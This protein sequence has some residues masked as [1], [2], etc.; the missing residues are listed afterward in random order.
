MEI[1]ISSQIE[2]TSYSFDIVPN[3]SSGSFGFG[4]SDISNNPLLS[5]SGI[6]GK[7]YDND[8]KNFFS[9]YPGQSLSFSGNIFSG[10]HNYFVNNIPLNLNCTRT[11]GK[12]DNFY[13]NSGNSVS[14]NSV[15]IN[16]ELPEFSISNVFINGSGIT[17]EFE[18]ENLNSERVFKFYSGQIISGNDFN[19]LTFDSGNI[20]SGKIFNLVSSF[21]IFD[22]TEYP[23]LARFFTNFGVIEKQLTLSAA[24]QIKLILGLSA[25]SPV[26]IPNKEGFNLNGTGDFDFLLN[27]QPE[28]GLRT[29]N[30]FESNILVSLESISGEGSTPEF[31]NFKSIE[32]EKNI[33]L[34]NIIQGSGNVTGKIDFTITGYSQIEDRVISTGFSIESG[35]FVYVT[36]VFND[37]I[38]INV[39]G[40][41]FGFI[42]KPIA[43]SGI[44]ESGVYQFS[45]IIAGS[46]KPTVNINISV[47]GTV[48]NS[49]TQN[50]FNI[51]T[52]FEV[53]Q[54]LISPFREFSLNYEIPRTS[55]I[56][57][58]SGVARDR[59]YFFEREFSGVTNSGIPFFNIG[60]RRRGFNNLPNPIISKSLDLTG[61]GFDAEGNLTIDSFNVFD[62]TGIYTGEYSHPSKLIYTSGII[63][64]SGAYSKPSDNHA[65]GISFYSGATSPM[66]W[67]IED[68]G[69]VKRLY[70]PQIEIQPIQAPFKY[71]D[72][73]ECI[74]FY[75][76]KT[77]TNYLTLDTSEIE[78]SF[79]IDNRANGV[80]L[81]SNYTPRPLSYEYNKFSGII[82]AGDSYN[83]A[84]V[85][86]YLVP[87]VAKN[88]DFT[89]Y[90][91][92]G[93]W[94]RAINNLPYYFRM[95][96]MQDLGNIDQS[97]SLSPTES[98]SEYDAKVEFSNYNEILENQYRISVF[99][100]DITGDSFYTGFF[101]V[102]Q[103][104]PLSFEKSRTIG[105]PSTGWNGYRN[106]VIS[107]GGNVEQW[108]YIG[109][110][111][112][113][114]AAGN[115]PIQW[116]SEKSSWQLPIMQPPAAFL[117]Q[118][119]QV[120]D[121][122]TEPTG[123]F[124]S[125][126]NPF[127]KYFLSHNI[128]HP[129]TIFEEIGPD[130]Q[131]SGLTRSPIP[132]SGTVE[133]PYVVGV[134]DDASRVYRFNNNEQI[135]ITGGKYTGVI[136]S[137][138]SG[139]VVIEESGIT[140]IKT[141]AEV[142]S[143]KALVGGQHFLLLTGNEN[144]SFISA[145]GLISGTGG[146]SVP[147]TNSNT[148]PLTNIFNFSA[149]A[150]LSGKRH[151]FNRNAD[152]F[153][154]ENFSN[155]GDAALSLS[156]QLK[157][158]DFLIVGY[159]E[160]GSPTNKRAIVLQY[161]GLYT[162][163]IFLDYNYTINTFSTI[164]TSETKTKLFTKKNHLINQYLSNQ[165]TL[166]Q[167][168]DSGIIEPN[169]QPRIDI[170][171][172]F[173]EEYEVTGI[174]ST[175]IEIEQNIEYSSVLESGLKSGFFDATGRLANITNLTIELTT[176]DSGLF[177][178]PSATGN[179]LETGIL[180]FPPNQFFTSGLE[181]SKP[182]VSNGEWL[183]KTNNFSTSMPINLLDFEETLEFFP[184]YKMFTGDLDI[185]TGQSLASLVSFESSSYFN[186]NEKKF[187][188]SGNLGEFLGEGEFYI[189]IRNKKEDILNMLKLTVS[190]EGSLLERNI[191][192]N[193]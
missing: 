122:T 29:A 66:P 167:V 188:N 139:V 82:S 151:Y 128:S 100:R 19:F 166:N 138:G 189:V 13:F 160:S 96:N 127:G 142:F 169:F 115:F 102:T 11:T 52:G 164:T 165:V 17:G 58:L 121:S 78:P 161:T 158:S 15:S 178:S 25:I 163:D 76:T 103:N 148:W 145:S 36:G 42:E 132:P 20:E 107:K 48:G 59:I 30:D 106:E 51:S 101:N 144:G 170:P 26:G 71:G 95:F 33:T 134:L 85:N 53:D 46:G 60:T 87:D 108:I 24:N 72:G 117:F 135:E 10:Y 7:F 130:S 8:G 3:N 57:G 91:N 55:F 133:N 118:W 157:S 22:E 146:G 129:D 32:S 79:I 45:G 174:V 93:I 27:Y 154:F 112:T 162:G 126:S 16:G 41:V 54:I 38:P 12:I 1:S 63:T 39:T 70:S 184:F 171:G 140:G 156:S 179:P 9:Y 116:E 109:A 183:T 111:S 149:Y 147:N 125:G 75:N 31:I 5:F 89:G 6:S 131:F 185:L 86:P 114:N 136:N 64:G 94:I 141:N 143:Y 28:I 152:R 49:G 180:G 2:Y 92:N 172:Y 56:S 155:T 90:L 61:L 67:N 192:I 83:N 123:L 124:N 187:I 47:T 104:N 153:L 113:L 80:A 40:E 181:L 68:S 35:K 176:E 84:G 43:I 23:F 69:K 81:V 105:V 182:F 191:Y 159:E 14:L 74:N 193:G 4:F 62:W 119:Q 97:F 34:S 37:P 50:I 99:L 18:V 73:F 77:G 137:S 186:E 88:E 175:G 177:L 98:G 21:S 65:S 168:I 120:F 190:G 44:I 150:E 110:R 173:Y